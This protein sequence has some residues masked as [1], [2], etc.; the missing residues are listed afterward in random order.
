MFD[1]P[2][3]PTLI[4]LTLLANERGTSAAENPD[5]VVGGLLAN[6]RGDHSREAAKFNVENIVNGLTGGAAYGKRH[7]AGRFYG[8]VDQPR[9]CGGSD[10]GELRLKGGRENIQKQ[11]R[12]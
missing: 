8:N 6:E 11:I 4:K 2:D 5:V 1:P 7:L 3:G 12:R 10:K 9:L